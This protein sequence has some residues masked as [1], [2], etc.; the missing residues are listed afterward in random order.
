MGK[1]IVDKR[2]ENNKESFLNALKANL[3]NV[4]KASEIIG[5]A[6]K[7][8]YDWCK[9]DEEFKSRA[10]EINETSIDFVESKLFELIEGVQKETG[11]GAVY[12]ASPCKTSIIFYLKT[13]AKQRGYVERQ[14]IQEIPNV[15]VSVKDFV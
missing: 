4:S 2:T 10:E 15:T 7:T 11:E 12:K 5:I 3:G 14:E 6:R 8:F 13:K 1:R 9:S